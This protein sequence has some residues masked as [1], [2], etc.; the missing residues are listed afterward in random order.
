[1]VGRIIGEDSTEFVFENFFRTMPLVFF[2]SVLGVVQFL[3][4]QRL[5]NWRFAFLF[6]LTLSLEPF[7][8]G[9]S[10]FLH[11]TGL[12]TMFGFTS[13]LALIY[14]LKTKKLKHVVLSAILLA[15]GI[16]T[17]VSIL[18]NLPIYFTFYILYLVLHL[19]NITYNS[20]RWIFLISPIVFSVALLI[21][22][23]VINPFLWQ[24][25]SHFIYK[26]YREGVLDTGFDEEIQASLFN[27]NML[28]YLEYSLYRLTPYTFIFAMIGLLLTLI[29]P[30]VNYLYLGFVEILTLF[31][32]K[33]RVFKYF[34]YLSLY[35]LK[36]AG[37]YLKKFH[38]H[39]VYFYMSI[40]LVIYYVLLSYPSKSRDRY[41][42]ELIPMIVF[43]AVLFIEYVYLFIRNFFEIGFSA[44]YL[45]CLP[46]IFK[47][48]I[49][50]V[51]VGIAVLLYVFG[52]T[53][54]A[55]VNFDRYHPVYSF[56]YSDLV[57]GAS[58]LYKTGVTPILRGEWYAQAAFYLNHTDP[59]IKQK[60]IWILDAGSLDSFRYFF[61]GNAV[62]ETTGFKQ[63]DT[64]EY[65][66]VRN[67]KTYEKL[68][69]ICKEMEAFG[70]RGYND[71]VAL[72]LFDCSMKNLNSV[73]N[74]I[75]KI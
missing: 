45:R 25:P 40:Y 9:V 67:G 74:R 27:N 21:A 63:Y 42:V 65:V 1:M 12:S 22:V 33:S 41:L 39:H 54:Y 44:P 48:F 49:T 50:H 7:F 35:E 18:I 15:L 69:Q 29:Y 56:Y 17:K 73:R 13:A 53:A 31:T 72:H 26:I 52:V 2:I 57:G 43:F 68:G 46:E 59:D 36:S 61:N 66:L 11:L 20:L 71:Y 51:S 47:K 38:L 64:I 37:D 24:D 75:G 16:S 58:G 30:F 62:R 60:D 70:P 5:I 55:K 4:L 10:R 8:L 32:K 14:F 23:Y 6:A 19:R 34:N 3:Y 28:F